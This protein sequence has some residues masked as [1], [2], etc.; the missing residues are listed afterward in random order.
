MGALF[1]RKIDFMAM[2]ELFRGPFWN[3]FFHH[4]DVFPVERGTVDSKAIRTAIQ[5]LKMGRVVCLYPEGG[6]RSG[7]RSILNGAGSASGAASLANMADVPVRVCIIVGPDQLYRWQNIF[8]RRPVYFIIGPEFQLDKNLSPRE[9]KQK[10]SGQIET[11]FREMY[12]SFRTTYEPPEHV[13]P[14]TAQERWA[15]KI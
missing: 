11:T 10:L 9:A 12:A 8:H 6:I 13:L 5:R 15:M 1:P 3:W 4:I 14:H 7:D 2:K